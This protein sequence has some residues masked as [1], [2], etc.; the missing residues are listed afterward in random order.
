[1][2]STRRPVKTVREWTRASFESLLRGDLL[3]LRIPQFAGELTRQRWKRSLDDPSRFSRYANAPDVKISTLGMT[4]FETKNKRERLN[5]YFRVAEQ[6]EERMARLF[7][8]QSSPFA[9]IQR[10]LAD[11]WPAGARVGTL[12]DRALCPGIIRKFEQANTDGLPPHQDM[13]H[14]DVPPTNGAVSELK[15]QVALNLYIEV[16]ERGGELEL[17]D[18]HLSDEERKT[19]LAGKH[20]FIDRD[21][22]PE[23]EQLRPRNGELI[24][25][26]SDHVHA[27]RGMRRENRVAASCFLGYYGSGEPIRYW[28]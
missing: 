7:S 23:P 25:F 8:P 10:R 14:K 22:L 17:W 15:T 18:V 20:D 1:M 24:L 27:V 21:G 4:L 5:K 26:R 16:P 28:A 9:L 2:E 19:L 3:A 11:L 6:F 12:C 13:L